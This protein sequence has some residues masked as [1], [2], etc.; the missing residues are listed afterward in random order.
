[1][2]AATLQ[3]LPHDLTVSILECVCKLII[4]QLSALTS[5][6]YGQLLNQ[7]VQLQLVSKSFRMLLTCSVRVDKIPVRKRLLELQIQKF[8]HYLEFA[9]I[10]DKNSYRHTYERYY[11]VGRTQRYAPHVSEVKDMILT[12][13]GPVWRSPAILS[14]LSQMFTGGRLTYETTIFFVS[15]LRKFLKPELVD[16][17]GKKDDLTGAF[18][19][20][21]IRTSEETLKG[22]IYELED[23]PQVRELVYT[24]TYSMDTRENWKSPLGIEFIA[25]RFK[26]PVKFPVHIEKLLEGELIGM[27]ILSF[28]DWTPKFH[29]E[30]RYRERIRT[31]EEGRYWLWFIPNKSYILIDHDDLIAE[32]TDGLRFD[33]AKYCY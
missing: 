31:G 8:T 28:K 4:E 25:G 30:D 2:S 17:L 24:Q 21:D 16:G 3:S 1:M 32:D 19:G 5:T 29:R 20:L 13:C 7:F 12:T 6:P 22:D 23:K 33:L 10:F 26:F 27:S 9:P 14:I 11:R 18:A 15:Q